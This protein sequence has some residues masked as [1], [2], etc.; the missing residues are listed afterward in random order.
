MTKKIILPDYRKADGHTWTNV[1]YLD[2]L[3]KRLDDSF[4]AGKITVD[5]NSVSGRDAFSLKLT[6]QKGIVMMYGVETTTNDLFS[7]S[8]QAYEIIAKHSKK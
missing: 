6:T 5:R 4:G 8:K 3:Q 1:E 7:V 2:E